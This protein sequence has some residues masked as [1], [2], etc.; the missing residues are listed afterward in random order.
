MPIIISKIIDFST[1][2]ETPISTK[3]ETPNSVN[4]FEVLE[5][6]NLFSSL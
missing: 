3:M 2:M 4:D 5:L 6:R 1:K